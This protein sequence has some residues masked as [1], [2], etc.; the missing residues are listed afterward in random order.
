MDS[1][2]AYFSEIYHTMFGKIDV[3]VS[4][5][6]DKLFEVF[7]LNF[8]NSMMG[9]LLVSLIVLLLV[10]LFMQPKRTA[11]APS[12][13]QIAFEIIIESIYGT[14]LNVFGNEKLAKRYF[15]IIMTVFLF[16]LISNFI[17]F[18]PLV[19]ALTFWNGVK[20]VSFFREPSADTS[21]TLGFA[22]ALIISA[23]AIGFYKDPL[24]KFFSYIRINKILEIRSPMTL[25]NF[26]I[27]MFLGILDIIGEFSKILSMGFRLFGN[28]FA[29]GLLILIITLLGK[30]ILPVPF[31]L[32]S[33]MSGIVQPFV[34]ALLSA[35]FLK[36]SSGE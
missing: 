13:L 35:I 4:L 10:Y 24:G 15:P 28:I 33:I 7:G 23:N 36:M 31:I 14:V 11:L 20:E 6:S 16:I 19:G 32:L 5:P 25:L 18:I 9:S 21:F 2:Q 17:S 27:E 1:I 34:Y 26:F 29:G 22:T 8:T 12:K 30:F 3:K